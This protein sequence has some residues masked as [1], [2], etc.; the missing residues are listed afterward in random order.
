MIDLQTR[1]S[2][3]L[4]ALGI[5]LAVGV[6]LSVGS[7]RRNGLGTSIFV[8]IAFDDRNLN[9][10]QLRFSARS[11]ASPMLFQPVLRPARLDSPPLPL[12]SVQQVRILLPDNLGGQLVL[13][14]VEGLSQGL[15]VAADR[16]EVTMKKGEEVQ[17]NLSLGAPGG[18][19]CGACTG[20]CSGLSCIAPPTFTGCGVGG[21][22]CA[23]C[24]LNLAS[25]CFNGVCQCGSGPA[26]AADLGSDSCINGECK[27]G[28]IKCQPGERCERGQC[29]CTPASCPNGCCSE[30]GC[31][32][33]TDNLAC[34]AA[35]LSCEACGAGQTCV[36]GVCSDC[37]TVCPGCC[38][39]ATCL[40]QTIATCGVNR[41]ACVWCDPV[42]ADHCSFGRCRCGDGG[43]CPPGLHC[44]AGGDC[45]CDATSCSNGCCIAN[46]CELF[47]PT[48]CGTRGTACVAC[49][50]VLSDQCLGGVCQCGGAEACR[51]GQ[52]CVGGRCQCN[53]RTCTGCCDS[54]TG[55]CIS[56]A[57][58]NKCG[59]AGQACQPCDAG[60]LC[61]RG[62]CE[63]CPAS[64]PDGC[65]S[66]PSCVIPSERACGINGAPCTSCSTLIADTC[67]AD[68]GCAC[69]GGSTCGQGQECRSGTC[70][71]TGTSCPSGCCDSVGGCRTR[72]I[73]NC[74]IN[75]DG[76]FACNPVLYDTCSS[77]GVCQCGSLADAGTNCVDGQRCLSGQCSCDAVSCDAGCCS[78]RNGDCISPRTVTACGPIGGVCSPCDTRRANVCMNGRCQCGDAGPCTGNQ[79][80][81][82]GFCL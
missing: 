43:S 14:S 27:C 47:S 28:A 29:K 58:P 17:S 24:D 44:V 13:V 69:G 63:S 45:R 78:S 77:G 74:G 65:C 53:S 75:G 57:D 49:D 52:E 39:G 33:G 26:C 31:L 82:A 81:D 21:N 71:C 46:R 20:C 9:I 60:E 35:G 1:S 6:S 80:C 19:D 61:T 67:L 37:P 8:Q 56:A 55:L 3:V 66:G 40:P 48:T 54:E 76:C 64:C 15:V 4:A 7:C 41:A 30:S 22:L 72:S 32:P 36:R 42:Q 25:R 70:S 38:S 16:G 79:S 12:Q 18:P 2:K 62:V 51:E 68:G 59:R 50:P 34:G 73:F 10:T 23:S 11:A 5:A